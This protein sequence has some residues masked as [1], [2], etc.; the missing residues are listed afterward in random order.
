M[1]IPADK[2]CPTPTPSTTVAVVVPPDT[3]TVPCPP[4]TPVRLED[5]S[6]VTTDYGAPT[7]PVQDATATTVARDLGTL[8][9]T[10]IDAGDVAWLGFAAIIIGIALVAG[11]IIDRRRKNR[12]LNTNKEDHP[13]QTH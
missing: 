2:P 10:S 6:C 8:P 3:S 7:E 9:V 12:Q 4:D 13:C 11:S 1:G 5:G